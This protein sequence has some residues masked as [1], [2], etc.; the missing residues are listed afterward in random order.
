[1]QSFLEL[2]GL[3]NLISGQTCHKNPEKPSSIDLI[4]TN[5]SSSFQNSCAIE[6]GLSDFPMMTTTVMKTSFKKL[7]PKLNYYKD[8]VMFSY[9]KFRE[10]LLSKL[11]MENIINTSSDLEKLLQVCTGVLD[12]LQKKKDNRGNNVPF[13]NK[14]LIRAHMKRSCLRNR[15]LKNRSEVN[16]INFIKQRNYWVSLLRKTEK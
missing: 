6:T 12:K 15:F 5:S 11:S 16:R 14:P 10:E 3:I 13:M 9:D 1:M 7:K 4:L 8:Y 2:Y